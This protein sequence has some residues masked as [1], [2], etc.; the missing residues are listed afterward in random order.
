MHQNSALVKYLSEIR[1]FLICREAN[2]QPQ[3]SAESNLA[4][5]PINAML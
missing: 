2:D 5:K 1:H 4:L 3:I